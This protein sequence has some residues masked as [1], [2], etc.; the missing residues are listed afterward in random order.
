M[1]QHEILFIFEFRFSLERLKLAGLNG[2][3][4]F[5]FS[6]AV[7]FSVA[8]DS[9]QE[10]DYYWDK[11]T[12]DGGEESQCGWLKDRYGLSWQIVPANLGDFLQF[13]DSAK[14]ER[15]MNAV[16][17]MKKLDIGKIEEAFHGE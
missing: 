13:D 16:L 9:Q 2:G 1:L 6:E 7:S 14:A 10:I 11:L 17:H 12:S 4:Q 5:K 15:A 8:C 3:P